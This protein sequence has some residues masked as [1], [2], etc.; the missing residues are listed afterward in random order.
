MALKYEAE[1]ILIRCPN[2]VGD[3]VMATPALRCM[4]RNYP[5]ARITLLVRPL[6]RKI[7]ADAPWYDDLITYQP[8]K[9]RLKGALALWSLGR[10]LRSR[11]FDL[12]LLLT[13]S[14]RA[15]FIAWLGGAKIRVANTRGDQGFLLTDSIPWPRE[16]GKRVPLPKVDAYMRLCELLGCEGTDDR[17]Q[18]L[19]FSE[20]DR[21]K[22]VDM[23]RRAGGDPETPMVGLVPGASYGPSKQWNT[24]Q[25]AVVADALI[26]EGRPVVPA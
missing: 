8:P 13:H 14:F 21:E 16:N 18:E 15:A 26:G 4:R 11:R 7:L 5:N 9:G 20:A 1:N 22:A 6:M 10:E 2:W 23:I 25:F 17:R 24:D 3:L 19:H 12:A